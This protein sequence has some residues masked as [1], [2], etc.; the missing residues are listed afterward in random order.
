MRSWLFN[1]SEM[2]LGQNQKRPAF[3]VYLDN[4]VV[5]IDGMTI[6]EEL[7]K[8]LCVGDPVNRAPSI[9]AHVHRPI[10]TERNPHRT[11]HP[12]AFLRLARRQPSANEIFRAALGLAFIVEFHADNLVSGRS[13]AIPRAMKCDED[14]VP[15]FSREL[16]SF[17]K[18]ESQRG[19][20][21]LHLDL[22][23]NHIL[24][25]IVARLGKF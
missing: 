21:R 1:E 8:L 19:G 6:D 11:P 24:A 9:V 13:A 5:V 22:R 25:T 20:V 7:S 23:R 15:V 14:V 4:A 3:F 12:A 17:I 2:A 16:R 18:R 10:T